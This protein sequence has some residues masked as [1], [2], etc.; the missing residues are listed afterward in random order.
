M[1]DALDNSTRLSDQNFGLASYVVYN[2]VYENVAYCLFAFLLPLFILIFFNTHLLRALKQSR[3]L[4]Q[5]TVRR[6]KRTSDENNVTLVMVVIIINFILFQTPASAN[7]ILYYVTD[8]ASKTT[9]SPYMM[10]YHLSN[11]LIT[12][13]SSSNFVIYCLFRRQFQQQLRCLIGV[14]CTPST[15]GSSCQSASTQ[16]LRRQ[17]QTK[18]LPSSV[19]LAATELGCRQNA[20]LSVSESIVS[21]GA[22]RVDP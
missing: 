18:T 2:I 8:H 16:S 14:G 15:V 20:A 4:R 1:T 3:R 21:V 7:Q 6:G 13:N 5:T 12:V 22:C 9:C 17:W 19:Q 10:Y 11:L